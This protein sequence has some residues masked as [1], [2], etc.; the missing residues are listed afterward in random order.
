MSCV[1]AMECC[2]DMEDE[3]RILLERSSVV[4]G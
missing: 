3:D 4:I 1:P 2:F